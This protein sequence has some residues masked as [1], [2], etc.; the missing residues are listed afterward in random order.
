M[1]GN[2]DR[3][4]GTRIVLRK[5]RSTDLHAI[6]RHVY[7]D[8]EVLKTMYLK[9]SDTREEAA[10][11]LERT[12]AY[13]REYPFIY[14]TA[15]KETDEVIGLC[16]MRKEAPGV[17]AEAGLAIGRA[18]QGKGYGTEMLGLLL[19]TAFQR[20]NAD[21]FI[22]TCMIDNTV[23]QNLA[24]HF[25]F[26]YDSEETATREYDQKTFVLQKFLLTKEDYLH[27]KEARP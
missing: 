4:E 7:G 3:L 10:A 27:D 13:Q 17:Y 5:A 25:G 18:H 26:H 1:K 24:L 19:E 9:P 12:I 22:Y 20:L 23:S 6:Y 2:F 15:L 11:R 21:R 14:F 8:R 16:G